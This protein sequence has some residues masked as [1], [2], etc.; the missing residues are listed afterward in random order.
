MTDQLSIDAGDFH[1]T[2]ADFSRCRRYRYA[3]YR[4]WADGKAA[5]FVGLNPSTADEHSN[6]PTIRRCIRFARDWGYPGLVM[7]NLYGWRAT[8]P[9]ELL[10]A[11]DPVGVEADVWLARLAA[12]AGIVVAAWGVNAEPTRA[13][14]AAQILRGQITVSPLDAMFGGASP[15]PLYVLGLTQGGQP[16]HPLYMKASAR[17]QEWKA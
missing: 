16:R 10:K 17:P 1:A 8:D 9:R 15:R 7:A 11:A 5:V 6:D 13:E 14:R 4:Q 12:R 3:L 2:G